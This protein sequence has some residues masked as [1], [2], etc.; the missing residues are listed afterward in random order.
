MD[1]SHEFMRI[2]QS[3]GFVCARSGRCYALLAVFAPPLSTL[4]AGAR[5]SGGQMIPFEQEAI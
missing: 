3:S 2:L 4:L 5:K 1:Q